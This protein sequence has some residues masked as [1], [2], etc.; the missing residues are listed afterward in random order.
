MSPVFFL[1]GALAGAMASGIMTPMDVIKTRL[2]T[3]TIPP[4]MGLI[5]NV[6]WILHENGLH[7]LYA[8][9]R[10]VRLLTMIVLFIF[11]VT[12]IVHCTLIIFQPISILRARMVW[13]GAFSAIG[14]GTFEAAKNFLG[15][16]KYNEP[17]QIQG[18]E[19]KK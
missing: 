15:V 2:A 5:G 12:N 4:N 6:Q 7:G 9:F 18:E 19:K 14:F 17:L 10:C 11:I 3:N 13:S 8:G 1:S 16:N